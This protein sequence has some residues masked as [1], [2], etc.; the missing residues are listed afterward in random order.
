MKLK[1]FIEKLGVTVELKE[2][3]NVEVTGWIPQARLNEVS[4]SKKE[5]QAQVDS[6]KE[7]ATKY[8]QLQKDVTNWKDQAE[9]VPALKKKMEEWEN[10]ATTLE[11]KLSESNNKITEF[12]KKEEEYKTKLTKTQIDAAIEK[13]LLM[14]GARY[15]DLVKKALDVEKI[16]LTDDGKIEGIKEQIEQAK[17]EFKDLFG[18]VKM[19][20]GTPNQGGNPEPV[21]E[22][23]MTDAEWIAWK[24]K[25]DKDNK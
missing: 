18:T 12:S 3:Q 10:N 8:E 14:N 11:Q 7:V 6:L 24:H 23:K 2:D 17:T 19:A 25:Q 22:S 15:P 4:E 13:E 16:K 20:G 21:D 9:S 1:E 5:L